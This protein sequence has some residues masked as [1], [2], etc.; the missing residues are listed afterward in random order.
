MWGSNYFTDSARGLLDRGV[1]QISARRKVRASSEDDAARDPRP[2]FRHVRYRTDGPTDHVGRI[3]VL[4]AGAQSPA[5]RDR[6]GDRKL[7][8]IRMEPT[9]WRIPAQGQPVIEA[10][11]AAARRP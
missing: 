11:L 9:D 2:D 8:R 10:T 3:A 1:P 6:R 5:H 7:R 4:P